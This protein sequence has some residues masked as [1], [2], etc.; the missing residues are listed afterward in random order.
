[1]SS[2]RVA[3]CLEVTPKQAFAS[4]LDWP[5][6]CRAGGDQDAALA[7]LATYSGRY[8]P[9]AGQ[10]GR[11][12][13]SA[14]A[15]DVVA[16]VPG[17]SATAFAAPECRRPFPQVTAEAERATVTPAAARRLGPGRRGLCGLRRDPAASPPELAGAHGAAGGP[18]P[19][20]RPRDRR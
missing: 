8:A 14:V 19:A 6:W 1:M 13:L 9:V 7:A 10:A 11:S 5:G 3:V 15:F 4:A 17:G 12:F 20:D 2:G 16:R 18:G